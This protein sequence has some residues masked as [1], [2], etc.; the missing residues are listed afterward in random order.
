M[1]E[2]IAFHGIAQRDASFPAYV[3]PSDYET[4]L[5]AA[6]ARHPFQTVAT[7]YDRAI[8]DVARFVDHVSGLAHVPSVKMPLDAGEGLK[9]FT[10]VS[11]LAHELGLRDIG[12]KSLMV[13]VGGGTVCNAAGFIAAMWNG[14]RQIVVPTNFLAFG[15]V[16]IGSLHMVNL[17]DHKNILQLYDDPLAVIL[18][19]AFL[20]TL[21]QSER[22]N[23]LAETVKHAIAQDEGLF[24]Q[25][26]GH[27]TAGTLLNDL[28]LFDLAVRTAQLKDKIMG[29]NPFGDLTQHTLLYGH[30]VAH[31]IEP[32]ADYKIPHG[33][34]V[35]LGLL[36]EL[37]FFHDSTSP[38]I[39]RVR[40]LLEGIGLPV[41]LPESLSIATIMKHLSHLMTAGNTLLIPRVEVIG[42]LSVV[43][44]SYTGE[45]DNT[46]VE[47]ALH[48][49][50]PS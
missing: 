39:K 38:I 41:S 43:D 27:V 22:R 46:A 14:M 40:A 10:R 19:P 32:A 25:L 50:A 37:A 24:E 17:A 11:E 13:V 6:R 15:D 26:E 34:A 2:Q 36:V 5:T 48:T 3:A 47:R 49:I 7:L 23:G 20:V 45:F 8:P 16:A 28:P 12:A 35:S 1:G 44:G 18:D 42:A 33:E 31:A 21:P 29:Q 4:V 30:V 9:S